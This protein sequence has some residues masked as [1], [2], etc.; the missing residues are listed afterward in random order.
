MKIELELEKH[1]A[2]KLYWKGQQGA[3]II[4]IPNEHGTGY[5]SA[6]VQML[7]DPYVGTRD[8]NV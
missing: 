8:T 3:I 4:L 5:D 2:E 6:E 1:D 7:T